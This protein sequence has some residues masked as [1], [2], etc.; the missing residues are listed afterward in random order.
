MVLDAHVHFWELGRHDCTWPPAELAAIHRDF[1]PDDWQ[2]VAA[3]LGIRA[4]IAVQS[5]PAGRDTEW[6]LETADADQRIVGVV[7]WT[8]LAA[9]DARARIEALAA[10]PKLRGLRPMLQDLPDDAWIL[11]DALRPA[12]EA[13]IAHGLRF[14][15]LVRA[16]QLRHL[17]RFAVRYPDLGIVIDHAGKPPI[18]TGDLDPWRAQMVALAQCRNVVCKLSGLVTEAG[19]DWQ[20]G[21]LAPCVGHLLAVFGPERLLWGSDW[22]VLDL[23]SDYADWFRHAGDLVQLSGGERAAVF[24]GN[25]ARFYGVGVPKEPSASPND[26]VPWTTV[27]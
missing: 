19:A 21:D 18:A 1:V 2:R 10:R 23:A 22:P 15:A 3:P 24:G 7:G 25:A 4:A 9:R 13:M 16:R 8:D 6:L 5:Q 27:P 14:D 12:I 20:P 11:K 17:V 26:R